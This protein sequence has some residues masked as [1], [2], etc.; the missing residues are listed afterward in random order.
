MSSPGCRRAPRLLSRDGID[1]R[2]VN[3]LERIAR[4]QTEVGLAILEGW[5]D[6]GLAVEAVAHQLKLKFLPLH[7]E[8]YDL[9]LRRRDYFEPPFQKLLSFTGSPT[10]KNRAEELG[11]Y[12][13]SGLGTVRYN[14]D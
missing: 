10:F 14:G 1:P 2:E 12:D 11:G 7:S 13:I 5:A 3:L 6:T 9:A 4:T 8:R